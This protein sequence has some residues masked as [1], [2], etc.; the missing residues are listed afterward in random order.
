MAMTAMAHVVVSRTLDRCAVLGPGQRAVI[1]VQGCPL[2]CPDCLAPQT[3]PFHGGT[4]TP[5]TDLAEWLIGLAGIEG[6]TLS[7]GEP[8]AQAGPL[9]LLL[10]EVRE[11]RPD[12]TAMSYS[13]FTHA[14]LRRGTAD[15]RALLDRL[16]LLIDGPYQR[17]RHADLRWRGS[18]NQRVIALSDRYCGVMLA[19]DVS[20]GI[21][22]TLDADGAMSWAG[23]PA[24][25]GFREFVES[26][27][28]ELGFDLR[29][30]EAGAD[31]AD[32]SADR[33]TPS[34]RER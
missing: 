4:A 12:F 14:A 5:V 2:R 1:W 23:V 26:G 31:G 6:V 20:Q 29:A 18:S 3:L 9:A 28:R 10:D 19:P 25:P 22:F 7:G 27:L 34:E 30:E 13:G 11:V 33:P 8:F 15:Q 24:E 16:D 21:E 32:A 17:A